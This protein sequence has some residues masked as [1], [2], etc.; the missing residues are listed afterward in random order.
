VRLRSAIAALA[1]LAAC[2]PGRSAPAPA[3]AAPAAACANA[4]QAPALPDGM[5]QDLGT[6]TVGDTAQFTISDSTAAFVIVSQ[7]DGTSAPATVVSGTTAVPNAV[8]P[9]DLRAPSGALYYDDFAAWPTTTFTGAISYADTTGLLAFDAGFQPA[10]GV[11]P[12]PGTSGGLSRL[13]AGSGVE[14]GTWTFVVNDWA[15]RC[16]LSSC[17]GGRDGGRYRV[18]VVTRPGAIPA[19]GTLDL[20]VYLATGATSVLPDAGAAAASAQVAR[21]KRGVAAYLAG[22]GIDLGAVTFHDLPPDV[23]ARWAANGR[24]DVGAAGPCS[25]LS[26][27]FT[28]A[29]APR[30]AVHLFLADVL[31]APAVGGG[32]FHVIGVDGSIPGPSGFPGTIYGGALVGLEDF[33]FEA[34]P[35]ACAP[36]TPVSVAS[37]GT[38]RTAYVAAHEIGH[39]LGL[40]HTT[41]SDGTFFDPI[42]DTEPCPCHACAAPGAQ[43][44][45][46]DV[47]PKGTTTVTNGRCVAGPTCGGGRNLMFWLL[48]DQ[49]STGELTP[50]QAQIMR[51]NPAVQ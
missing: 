30:R 15:H 22:A 39:W 18:S 43:A 23:K 36:S 41:E 48:S 26:L 25:P 7:E 34:T 12:F 42:A 28:S 19:T 32:P 21:W 5:V 13:R 51:L 50:D 20:E 11:F 1:L 45:C 3:A 9:T 29:T 8:V 14:R 47:N 10:V 49:V 33:G 35:G 4:V 44:A 46:A 17:A 37:C 24:V 27:L 31:V 2:G 38:D 40:F 16:P 6:L